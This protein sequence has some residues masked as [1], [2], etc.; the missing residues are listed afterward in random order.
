MKNISIQCFGKDTG[1]AIKH[2]RPESKFA[3]N[4]EQG[5]DVYIGTE[6]TIQIQ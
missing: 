5:N 6:L 3:N 1:L 2:I 4:T